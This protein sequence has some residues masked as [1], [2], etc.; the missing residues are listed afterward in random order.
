MYPPGTTLRIPFIGFY[1]Y[2]IVDDEGGVIH[3]SKKWRIVKQE[4]IEAF[5]EGK[6]IEVCAEI[7]GGDG[8]VAVEKAKRY[9]N[10]PYDLFTSNCEHFVRL[11]H[12][13]DKESTQLQKYMMLALDAGIAVTAN[14]PEVK[15][16]GGAVV[17][18]SLLTED[19]KSPYK[20]V[21]GFN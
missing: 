2:G 11:V 7:H 18:A 12:G 8:L 13:Y 4:S 6:K 1:H 16:V 19:G 15:V 3:N 5:A 10:A 17:L 9:I 21:R 14:N 20:N